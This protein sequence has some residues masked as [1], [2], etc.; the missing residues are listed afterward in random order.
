M[1][2]I[3]PAAELCGSAAL[4]KLLSVTDE[5]RK[6]SDNNRTASVSDSLDSGKIF[7]I[8]ADRIIPNH[9]QPRKLFDEDAILRLADSIRRYGLL[10]P[11]SVRRLC[12][13]DGERGSY[14]IVAGERRFRAATLIGMEYIPCIIISADDRTAAELALIENIQREGLSM[15]EQ[16]GA[17]AAL[18]DIYSLTQEQI[19]AHLSASQSYVAN[20][21]RLLK[22][23]EQERE[24]ITE[25]RLTERHAR[26]CLK[27]KDEDMRISVIEHV[28]AHGLNVSATEEYIDRKLC[29]LS[30]K[31]VPQNARKRKLILKDMRLFYNSIDKAIDIVKQSGAKVFSERHIADEYGSV[32]LVIKISPPDD[33]CEL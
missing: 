12:F 6:E 33:R 13:R 24:L 3:A 20:K 28:I 17:I 16:A 25:G 26:A 8:S 22:L 4:K 31:R 14:E 10:Q 27:I 2:S 11:L 9:A 23:S 21:L 30:E 32:E 29:M 7:R 18:I 5:R 15:F 19:A 1:S